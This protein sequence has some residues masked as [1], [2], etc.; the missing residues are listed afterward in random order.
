MPR[1]PDLPRKCSLLWRAPRLCITLLGKDRSP[2]TT[3]RKIS[4]RDFNGGPVVKSL[5][6]NAGDTS[7]IPGLGRSHLPQSS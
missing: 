7:S 2:I 6:V 4:L 5:P 1:G 3:V